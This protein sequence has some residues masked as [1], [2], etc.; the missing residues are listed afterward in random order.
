MGGM[1]GNKCGGFELV[2][3]VKI[4]NAFILDVGAG[5]H[6]SYRQ[7]FYRIVRHSNFYLFVVLDY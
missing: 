6:I 3:L 4:C 7:A 1:L 5:T 2:V